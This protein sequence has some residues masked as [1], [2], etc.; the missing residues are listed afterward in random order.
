MVH[1]R[2]RACPWDTVITS[3]RDNILYVK[4]FMAQ[5]ENPTTVTEEMQLVRQ[6]YEELKALREIAVFR[7]QKKIC[8]CR[9]GDTH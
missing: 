3:A 9:C 2:R 8:R 1:N 4:A 5:L 7:Q 6:A